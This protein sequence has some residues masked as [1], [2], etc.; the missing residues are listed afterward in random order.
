MLFSKLNV[1]NELNKTD[2]LLG[3][4]KVLLKWKMAE[5]SGIKEMYVI[6]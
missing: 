3:Q 2:E 5:D 1:E 6:K 4:P